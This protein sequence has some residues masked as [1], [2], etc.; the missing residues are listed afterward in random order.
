L[1]ADTLVSTVTDADSLVLATNP[2]SIGSIGSIVFNH[3]D[4]ATFT[5]DVGALA[6]GTSSTINNGTGLSITGGELTAQAAANSIARF[7][8]GEYGSGALLGTSKI[9]SVTSNTNAVLASTQS[10]GGPIGSVVLESARS[11]TNNYTVGTHSLFAPA[12][13]LQNIERVVVAGNLSVTPKSLTVTASGATK[14][15]DGL[16]TSAAQ[17]SASGIV[18]SV[19]SSVSVT[20]AVAVSGVTSFSSRNVGAGNVP[21]T[22]SNIGVT[23]ADA[24]NYTVQGGGSLSFSKGTI[25]PRPVTI[26]VGAGPTRVYSGAASFAATSAER[27][28]ITLAGGDT[29][30]SFLIGYSDKNAGTGKAVT[31][32]GAAI[33]D[34]NGGN[35][36]SITY[37][38]GVT[39]TITQRPSVAWIGGSTGN[40]FDSTKWED[41]AVPDLANVAT[42]RIPAG[43]TVT[44]DPTVVSNTS[45]SDAVSVGSITGTLV[46]GGVSPGALSQTGGT[47]NVSGLTKLSGWAQASG[48]TLNSASLDVIGTSDITASGVHVVTGTTQL[49][50]PGSDISLSNAANAF[51]GAMTLNGDAIS[52]T[53]SRATALGATLAT[54]NLTVITGA[55][56]SLGGVTQS[57][58]IEVLGTTRFTASGTQG[59]T[60]TLNGNNLFRGLLVFDT[61]SPGT[62]NTISAT[63]AVPSGLSVI[64]LPETAGSVSLTVPSASIKLEANQSTSASAIANALTVVTGA[65]L[66]QSGS[67]AVSGQTQLNV[68]GQITFNDSLNNFIGAV[69]V[70]N[71]AGNGA[72]AGP[73]VIADANT[74]TLGSVNTTGA[75][76]LRAAT[77]LSL[78]STA[79][80]SL[81]ATATS[82]DIH[83]TAAAVISG[84]TNLIA[85][86]DITLTQAANNFVGSVAATGNDIRIIDGVAGIMLGNIAS[87]GTDAGLTVISTNGAIAQ[88]TSTTISSS[89][90]TSLNAQRQ[91]VATGSVS[92]S[93]NSTALNI[94]GGQLTT[95]VLPGDLV[96]FYSG[97]N[98]TGALMG[99]STISSVIDPSTAFL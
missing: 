25:E 92:A 85:G 72:S 93:Q 78:G 88:A 73:V 3:I 57:G 83:Q 49:S 67:F 59:Q 16:L 38:Q 7:Y 10:L 32:S 30:N 29:L 20:D 12:S 46:S 15:Y 80:A 60:A 96:R 55:G 51:T 44:Y 26:T 50:V 24:G 66:T 14:I 13:S 91:M 8:A 1:L 34:G 9:A 41:G 17:V 2:G 53:N 65:N 56:G 81:T 79:A 42:V 98:G 22:I 35:N 90:I 77:D 23:G 11:T 18:S 21:Y 99:S 45:G 58:V 40:W 82:G 61:T 76:T 54:G 31:F 37:A 86:D 74:L 95:Q 64:L 5:L 27:G 4:K 62:W 43:V 68:S 71:Q 97:A 75:L 39:G 69:S 6:R 36:Y 84:L 87:S 89:G 28:A 52:V 47:I 94:S 33:A 19:V 70:A 48:A 63:N